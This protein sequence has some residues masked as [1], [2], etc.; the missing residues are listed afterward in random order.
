MKENYVFFVLIGRY[1]VQVLAAISKVVVPFPACI[2]LYMKI[3][4]LFPKIQGY[5]FSTKV[6]CI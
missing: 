6:F 4:V 2:G 1:H 5:A 3:L